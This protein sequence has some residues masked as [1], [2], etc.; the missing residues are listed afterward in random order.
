MQQLNPGSCGLVYGSLQVPCGL[1]QLLPDRYGLG[2]SPFAGAASDTKRSAG[3]LMPEDAGTEIIGPSALF[4]FYIH[5]IPAAER[6][7][8]IHEIGR[9]H[10]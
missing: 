5:F 7:R 2:A 1:L 9:A 6:A 8:Y 4:T 3:R 10:V